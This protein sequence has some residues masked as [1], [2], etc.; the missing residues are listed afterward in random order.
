MNKNFLLSVNPSPIHGV[1]SDENELK[2]RGLSSI[3][4][5]TVIRCLKNSNA[6][7]AIKLSLDTL[8]KKNE[9]VNFKDGYLE[10]CEKSLLFELSWFHRERQNRRY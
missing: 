3:V 9:S 1:F 10:K 8:L 6:R 4:A 5:I 2:Y 7:Q